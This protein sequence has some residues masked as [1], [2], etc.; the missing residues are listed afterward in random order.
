MSPTYKIKIR[1]KLS[2][3]SNEEIE[4]WSSW[5]DQNPFSNPLFFK[6]LEDSDCIGEK[7]GWNPLYF[8]IHSDHQKITHR[9]NEK[10]KEGNGEEEEILA[11]VIGFVK[12]HSY[13]EYIFDWQWAQAYDNYQIPYYPKLT[14]AIPHSPVSAPKFLGDQKLIDQILISHIL[15]FA[16]K[17]HLSGTH[18]LF[19][20]ENENQ[21]LEKHQFL[22]RDSL[23]YHFK[24]LNFENFND[25]LS[26]LKKNRRKN[27]KK[28]RASLHTLR[29]DLKIK[30][31]SLLPS[32]QPLK[33]EHIRFFYRCYQDTIAKK[34]SMAYLNLDFFL[35]L[36]KNLPETLTLII[37]EKEDTPIAS[38]LFLHSQDTLYGRYWGCLEDISFLHFELCIY[39]GIEL[40]IEKKLK[41]FEAGAQGEHKLIRGFRPTLT[42][43]AHYLFHPQFSKAIEN[44]L[45]EEKEYLSQT[46]E[47][48]KK[49]SSIK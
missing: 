29:D 41:T 26:Q 49:L 33:E 40:T 5:A 7:I 19:T 36:F 31:H 15:S 18:F 44:F 2:D 6:A 23:Q 27:I 22:I 13:G 16:Q 3:F 8:S 12:T 37:A 1:D 28:E 34:G 32:D 42:K 48:L 46:I 39:Q 17:N 9:E 25:Y 43:S 11:L 10:R 45:N 14:F 35:H 4:Q 24:N 21:I 38:S 20:Q 47:D 30:R